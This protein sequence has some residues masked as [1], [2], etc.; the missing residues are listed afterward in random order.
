MRAKFVNEFKRG[1]DPKETLG[2]GYSP[3]VK[4]LLRK[5]DVKKYFS[6]NNLD[7]NDLNGEITLYDIEMNDE[8]SNKMSK[9]YNISFETEGD[10]W[11]DWNVSGEFF[12]ILRFMVDEGLITNKEIWSEDEW[13]ES[14]DFMFFAT[15]EDYYPIEDFIK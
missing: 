5:V 13:G 11:G 7:M 4:E 3:R 1:G 2:I 14:E 6:D 8:Y 12:D 9:E 15:G 10:D